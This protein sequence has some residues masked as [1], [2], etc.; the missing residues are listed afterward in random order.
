[1][2]VDLGA[3]SGL[4][5]RVHT[6]ELR[7]LHAVL[8]VQHGEPVF[9]AHFSGPDQNIVDLVTGK[10][11]ASAYTPGALHD[12]RSV[13]KSVTS[14]LYGIALADGAVP[15]PDAPVI[16]SFPDYADLRTAERKRLLVRHLLTMTMGVEWDES[17]SY[18]DPRNS[19]IQMVRSD[20]PYRF[21][22]SRPVVAPPGERFTYSGGATELVGKLISDGTRRQI[23]AYARDVL[24]EPLG[25]TDFMWARAPHGRPMCASGLRLRAPDLAKIA[26]L[27]LTGGVH[28]GRV[29]APD[30]WLS[31]SLRPHVT[32]GAGAYGFFFW[33]SGR[34]R[35]AA[36]MGNGGQRA[37]VIPERDV[38]VVILAGNYDDFGP[39]VT[40]R[41]MREHV[42]PAVGLPPDESP[43]PFLAP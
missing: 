5:D 8:V 3:L 23:D 7:N 13:T 10:S 14:L 1:M 40:D 12:V 36:A 41:V 4:A 29:V 21:V 16:E 30:T 6:G 22:L 18:L 2:S 35:V 15:S 38:V 20:D 11:G 42:L 26:Q 39:S 24:F 9:E 37:A 27:Y 34:G 25:I 33:L 28:G 43:A 31:E 17:I 19:E 32:H